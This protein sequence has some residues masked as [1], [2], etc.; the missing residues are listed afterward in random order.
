MAI[1]R[2]QTTY[3]D[4]IEIVMSLCRIVVVSYECNI[5]DL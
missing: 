4:I 5:V 2:T 3:I 1:Y